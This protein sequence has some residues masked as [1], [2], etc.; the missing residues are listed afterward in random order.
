MVSG[1]QANVV[2]S[3]TCLSTR[4][5]YATAEA[6]GIGSSIPFPT[7]L[8][9]VPTELELPQAG[10]GNVSVANNQV[11][12]GLTNLWTNYHYTVEQSVDLAVWTASDGFW[13]LGAS[14][15]WTATL[16]TNAPAQFY[17][18]RSP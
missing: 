10:M 18:L 17:R 9:E 4:L 15:N 13:S 16:P 12:L 5:A 2:I 14:T 1:D 3:S 11:S 7:V 8:V 6:Q